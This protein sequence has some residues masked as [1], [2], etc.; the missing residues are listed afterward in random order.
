MSEIEAL[1]SENDRLVTELFERRPELLLPA[2]PAA[3]PAPA[4][5]PR[6]S[7]PAAAA[8]DPGLPEEAGGSEAPSAGFGSDTAAVAIG[9]S[10][11]G[12]SSV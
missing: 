10:S 12:L 5:S 9:E 7:P 6:S 1:R 4:S 11:A 3:H 2:D 8:S